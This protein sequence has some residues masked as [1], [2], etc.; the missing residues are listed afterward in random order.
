MSHV[1]ISQALAAAYSEINGIDAILL[2][3]HVLSVNHAFLLTHPDQALTVQ[4]FEKFSSLVQQR[5]EGL[6]VA[7]LIGERAFFDLTFKVTD[8]VLIPRPETELLVEWALELIPSQ[9]SCKVLDLGTGSGVIGI[10]IAKHRP[11]AQ[12]I[13]V[14]LSPAAIDVCQSNVEILEVA[15]LNTIRGNWFDELSGEKYDLIV[16]NPPYVAEGD[17]HL[18]Q[19]DLRFEPEMALSAGEH[20]MACITHIINAAPGYLREEGWL[21]LEHGYD[22]AE[23]CRQ[24]LR[25]MDFSNICSYPDLAGI[26]RVSGG[27]LSSSI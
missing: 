20:G 26:M 9:K 4:Q 24:L 11:Q 19:G 27:Q 15:N 17:P 8:A 14:D 7:Y 5:I 23:A 13:A 21:L 1:T 3:R 22:Q 2:L 12:V 18:Q 16:S 6:P 10:T 25:D